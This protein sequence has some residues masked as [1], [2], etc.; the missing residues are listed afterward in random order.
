MAC[1]KFGWRMSAVTSD[2]R[3]S[4]HELMARCAK[5]EES[6]FEELVRRYQQPIVDYLSRL[7]G[8]G[9]RAEE[10]GQEVFIR[11]FRHRSSYTQEAGFS[12]WCYTIATNLARDER[13]MLRRRPSSSGDS[14]LEFLP[15]DA[16]DPARSA[17]NLETRLLVQR[18]LERLPEH[19]REALV[20]RDLQGC[21]YQEISAAL[22]MELGTVKSRINRARM[23]FKDVYL[24]L[25][26]Q[27][28][29]QVQQEDM[30]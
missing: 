25:D 17:Q 6:S 5:G 24:A 11:V 9:A 16:D 26:G 15:S 2:A 28:G 3:S 20:L 19:F 1:H 14:P 7:L 21:S 12:T 13:R 18:A 23:A 22:G 30:R 29:G 10:L 4:D 8:N 27:G